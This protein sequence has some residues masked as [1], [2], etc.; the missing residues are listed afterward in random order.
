MTRYEL[1][2]R[3]KVTGVDSTRKLDIMRSI[4][5]DHAIDYTQETF[6]KSGRRYDLILDMAV[7]H[8][9]F[10]YFRALSPKGIY[11]IG[12]GSTA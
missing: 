8:S 10:D 9:I 6:T 3:V 4:G 2:A 11:V 5:A 12:G 1:T 7:H